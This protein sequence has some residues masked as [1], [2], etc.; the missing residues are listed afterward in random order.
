MSHYDSA[1][2]GASSTPQHYIH[3]HEDLGGMVS[4][5]NEAPLAIKSKRC[6]LVG[7]NAKGRRICHMSRGKVCIISPDRAHATNA[8]WSV[9]PD[10]C[11]IVRLIS[12]KMS[13][14]K[15][16]RTTPRGGIWQEKAGL[17]HLLSNSQFQTGG[18]APNAKRSWKHTRAPRQA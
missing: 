12:S 17:S 1:M 6:R 4:T 18:R 7:M 10:F 3:K 8:P 15:V 16:T 13:T 9:L 14:A 5:D 2:N 11:E